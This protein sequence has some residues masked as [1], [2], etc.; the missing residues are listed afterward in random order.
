MN[1]ERDLAAKFGYESPVWDTIEQ[2]HTCYNNNVSHLISNM[3][4]DDMVFVASHN[5]DSVK[6]A[7]ELTEKFGFKESERVRFG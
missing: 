5:V 4:I 1:E 6:L 3:K 7:S 2:T